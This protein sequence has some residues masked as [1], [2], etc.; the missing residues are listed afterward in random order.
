MNKFTKSLLEQLPEYKN[1]DDMYGETYHNKCCRAFGYNQ[2]I[3]EIRSRLEK[4]ELC[5]KEV[6]KIMHQYFGFEGCPDD[7]WDAE[8]IDICTNATVRVREGK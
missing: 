6:K 3:D 5:P 7:E 4:C 2:A 8:V 1:P